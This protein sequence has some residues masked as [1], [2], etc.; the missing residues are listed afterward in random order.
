[1]KKAYKEII[2]KAIKESE[3]N[4]YK[5]SVKGDALHWSYLSVEHFRFEMGEDYVRVV[6]VMPHL[7]EEETFI[8]LIVGEEFYV[9]AK[10][11]EEALAIA[12]KATIAKA[13]RL[14]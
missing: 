3:L 5:W 8:Y 11:M 9:D 2:T 12:T 14:F 1:M 4:G 10:S 6:Y 7:L 13:N